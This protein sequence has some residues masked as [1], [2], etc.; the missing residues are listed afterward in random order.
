MAVRIIKDKKFYLLWL[1][2]VL[3][4]IAVL[5]YATAQA[6]IELSTAVLFG[7]LIQ[8]TLI[9]AVI[10][11]FGIRFAEK[12]NFQITSSK[13]C[14][15][16]SIISGLVVGLILKL[17]DQFIFKHHANILLNNLPD[18]DLLYRVL[19]S[20]YGAINEEVLLRLF[21]VSCVAM[22]LQKFTKLNKKSVAI[23]S[24]ILCALLFAVGHLP[25]LYKMAVDP[26]TYD[27]VRVLLLNGFAGI[28]FGLLYWRYGL[29][30]SMLSHFIADLVIHVFWIL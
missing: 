29:V 21:G 4:A 17:L 25:M 16:P 3:G 19:A 27:I 28:A 10:T 6:S 23:L 20:F 22:L 11:F 5:P 8:A 7:T 26:N 2:S 13:E 14:I 30:A 15:I 9:Y 12:A 18:V 24:I 1:A